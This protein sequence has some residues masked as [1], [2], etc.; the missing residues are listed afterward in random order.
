MER[1]RKPDPGPTPIYSGGTHPSFV[2]RDMY[3]KKFIPER[4]LHDLFRGPDVVNTDLVRRVSESMQDAQRFRT[5][6]NMYDLK[7]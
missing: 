4:M 6:M 7:F 1:D 3:S 2:T 5:R